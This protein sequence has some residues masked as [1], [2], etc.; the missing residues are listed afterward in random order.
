MT[1]LWA[2]SLM[3]FI[4]V[5]VVCAQK[6]FRNK[7]LNINIVV[8]W[9]IMEIIYAQTTFP[10]SLPCLSKLLNETLRL[11]ISALINEKDAFRLD[12]KVH[13]SILQKPYKCLCYPENQFFLG[14]CRENQINFNIVFALWFVCAVLP[15]VW[16]SIS[17]PKETVLFS[18]YQEYYLKHVVW[19]VIRFALNRNIDLIKCTKIVPG[20]RKADF[21]NVRCITW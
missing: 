13:F 6:V 17:I 4:F 19:L 10:V 3:Y 16:L 7:I 5:T 8:F 2:K 1:K 12:S 15:I 11:Q 9:T 14:T 21:W 20:W 18:G